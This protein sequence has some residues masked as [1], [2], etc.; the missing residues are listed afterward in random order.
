MNVPKVPP[1]C[2]AVLP[3]VWISSPPLNPILSAPTPPKIIPTKITVLTFLISFEIYS[4]NTEVNLI[5]PDVMPTTDPIMKPIFILSKHEGW[6]PPAMWFWGTGIMFYMLFYL[7]Y[8]IYTK[9]SKIV[10]G[11][12][13]SPDIQD[14]RVSKFGLLKKTTAGSSFNLV[15]ISWRCV[16]WWHMI[17][18]EYETHV[19][20]LFG[21]N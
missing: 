7:K 10:T 9:N 5:S 18:L 17:L 16:R 4:L 11:I 1:P 15:W 20:Q 13:T 8:W 3:T 2:K 6:P 19:F 12:A 21:F 14:R